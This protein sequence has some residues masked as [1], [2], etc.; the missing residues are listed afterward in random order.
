M[1]TLARDISS[2]SCLKSALWAVH[3]CFWTVMFG[4]SSLQQINRK[5]CYHGSSQLWEKLWGTM[6][7]CFPFPAGARWKGRVLP[8]PLP[9]RVLGETVHLASSDGTQPPRRH[10]NKK[11]VAWHSFCVA[12]FPLKAE[13]KGQ[14]GW[15]DGWVSNETVTLCSAQQNRESRMLTLRER[16]ASC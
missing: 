2:D 15:Y 9:R 6:S 13:K 16:S 10:K 11:A 7:S 5:D 1:P 14:D 8:N 3:C 4:S 12:T